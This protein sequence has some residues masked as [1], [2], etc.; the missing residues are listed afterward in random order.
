MTHLNT[1]DL[2]RKQITSTNHWI[3]PRQWSLSWSKINTGCSCYHVL[4]THDLAMAGSHYAAKHAGFSLVI[5][6][7]ETTWYSKLCSHLLNFILQLTT[8]LINH[9]KV[10]FVYERKHSEPKKNIR[11]T[12]AHLILY[13]KISKISSYQSLKQ[14]RQISGIE[15]EKTHSNFRRDKAPFGWTKKHF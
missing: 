14:W 13:H 2:T 8:N 11:Q 5:L 9:M 6:L 4:L 10:Q 3:L 12:C 15:T 1:S 7:C